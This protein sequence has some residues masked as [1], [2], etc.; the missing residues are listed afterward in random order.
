MLAGAALIIA[1]GPSFALVL[2]ALLLQGVT[3]G[4]LGPG[5]TAISLG[6]VGHSALAERLGRNQCF[7]S[8][9]SLLAAACMGAI[10]Y[11]LSESQ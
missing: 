2:A 9:G 3:G 1:L 10:G 4:V 6:I 7:K 8:T 5:I 11:F